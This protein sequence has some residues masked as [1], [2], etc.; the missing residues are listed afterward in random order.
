V[1]FV[2]ILIQSQTE[3][4]NA[5]PDPPD[6]EGVP[7]GHFWSRH[8]LTFRR[9]TAVVMM[10]M[11][12]WMLTVTALSTDRGR[13]SQSADDRH[14]CRRTAAVIVEQREGAGLP[15]DPPTNQSATT[16]RRRFN[17]KSIMIAINEVADV[18]SLTNSGHNWRNSSECLCV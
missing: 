10:L 14:H 9:R 11:V 16:L 5:L 15:F 7:Y 12:M 1:C 13:Y 17:Q 6:D 4:T 8:V 18:S 3:Q 2:R